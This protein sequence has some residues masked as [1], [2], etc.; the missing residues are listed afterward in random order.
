MFGLKIKD[1]F[2][3]KNSK[4]VPWF[5]TSCVLMCSV[6]QSYPDEAGHVNQRERDIMAMWRALQDKMKERKK[7]LGNREEEM[8]FAEEAKDLVSV[9]GEGAVYS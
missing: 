9:A 4:A 5:V 7:Q 8:K 2:R 3:F 6:R 1:I